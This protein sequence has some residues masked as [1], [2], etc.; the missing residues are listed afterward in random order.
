MKTRSTGNMCRA[1]NELIAQLTERGIKVMKHTLDNEASLEYLQVIK[2]N[3]ITPE[4]VPPHI[5]LRNAAK[6]T[7]GIFKDHFQTGTFGI[8]SYCRWKIC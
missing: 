4:K 5:H 3:G 8:S 7:I 6:K 1:Y 2:Q